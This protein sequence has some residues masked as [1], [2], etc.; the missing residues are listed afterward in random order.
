MSAELHKQ[1]TP[2][3]PKKNEEYM[4]ARQLAHFRKILE[5]WILEFTFRFH[6]S[7]PLELTAWM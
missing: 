1:F 3:A 2:Y 7:V 6:L 5:D 4:N